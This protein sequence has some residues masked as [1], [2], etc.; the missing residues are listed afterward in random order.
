MTSISSE[1]FKFAPR[2]LPPGKFRLRGMRKRWWLFRPF[3]LL[4]RHWPVRG[5]FKGLLIVRI[6]GIGDM[7]LFRGALDHYAAA[8]GVPREEIVILGCKSWGGLASDVFTGYR[9]HAIDEHAFERHVFYRFNVGRWVRRQ[10]FAI[11]VCD[12][13]FRKALAA[14]SLVWF[15]GAPRRILGQPWISRKTQAEFAYYEG[16]EPYVDTGPYPTHEVLRHFNF[17]NSITGRQIAPKPPRL[18]WQPKDISVIPPGKPYIVLNFGANEPGRRWPFGNFVHVGERILASGYRVLLTGTTKELPELAAHGEFF[19][20]PGIV[21]LVGKTTISQVCD[22]FARAVAVVTSE[23]GPG[24]LAI[25]I[26]T[27]TIMVVGGGQFVNFVPFPDSISIP[28]VYFVYEMMD[29]Y[30]CL[31]RCTKPHVDG[32]A[33]PCVQAISVES[34]WVHLQTLLAHASNVRADL[35]SSDHSS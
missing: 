20:R 10:R 17:L 8:F 32:S 25:A 6:D 35:M 22:I 7:V 19:A 21:N 16:T 4:A 29:C 11:A 3:D 23:T 30:C 13:F 26:G 24:H 18:D 5:P 31:W 27:P 15:S 14:D 34:V 12:S 33:F 2:P 1:R 9:V 28:H